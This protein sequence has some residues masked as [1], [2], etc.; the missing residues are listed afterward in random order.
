MAA[1]HTRQSSLLQ[2]VSP[3]TANQMAYL[4]KVCVDAN[5]TKGTK[6]DD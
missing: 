6:N 3:T 5:A 2:P 4:E 1:N